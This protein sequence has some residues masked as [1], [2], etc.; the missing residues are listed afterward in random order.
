M[1]KGSLLLTP[2]KLWIVNA[3][4][5]PSQCLLRVHWGLGLEPQF[6][7]NTL[8]SVTVQLDSLSIWLCVSCS[9][10]IEISYAAAKPSVSLSPEGFISIVQCLGFWKHLEGFSS[11]APISDS[12]YMVTSR[13]KGVL[14]HQWQALNGLLGQSGDEHVEGV[15]VTIHCNVMYHVQYTVYCSYEWH[16]DFHVLPY[17]LICTLA[18]V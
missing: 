3:S 2:S 18:S 4:H 17:I 16:W 11:R 1:L 7:F 10:A 9:P 8:L 12:A 15:G 5:L 14:A 6:T 13:T